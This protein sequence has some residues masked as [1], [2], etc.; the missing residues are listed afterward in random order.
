M[1]PLVKITQ[2]EIGGVLQPTVDGRELWAFFKP[3]ST[4]ANWISNKLRQHDFVEGKDYERVA[5]QRVIDHL[6][7][8]KRVSHQVDYV[9]SISMAERIGALEFC[10]GPHAWE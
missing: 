8:R 6:P 4:F 9:M 5:V 2:R 10:R 3:Y 1:S 7:G